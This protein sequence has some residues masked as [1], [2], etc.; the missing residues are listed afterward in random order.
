MKQGIT[1]EWTYDHRDKSIVRIIKRRGK[2]SL[3]EIGDLL[4]Y[5]DGQRWCGAYA[6]LLN[7]TEATVGGNGLYFDEDPKGDAV[8]LYPL[9]DSEDC[10]VCANVLPPFRYCPN[11][12]TSWKDAD[13]TVEKRLKSMREE[14]ER[15]LSKPSLTP[16]AR[17]AWYWTFIGSVDMARQLDLITEARRI[18]IYKEVEAIKP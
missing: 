9:E 11:C 2:L 4:R 8:D 5:E 17:A 15:E 7:C 16:E 10:P 6:I 1:I 14:T 3:E 13:D 12:G 18:E